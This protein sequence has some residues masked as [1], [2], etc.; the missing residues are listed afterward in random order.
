[1]EVFGYKSNGGFA[2]SF[3][4]AIV[5]LFRKRSYSE[6]QLQLFFLFSKLSNLWPWSWGEVF[7]VSSSHQHPQSTHKKKKS[8]CSVKSVWKTLMKWIVQLGCL[9][10]FL[11]KNSDDL[12]KKVTTAA[13][14]DFNTQLMKDSIMV[15]RKLVVWWLVVFSFLFLVYRQHIHWFS[16]LHL[17][18]T[19]LNGF[20]CYCESRIVL[21]FL[22]LLLLHLGSDS[23][24]TVE[25]SRAVSRTCSSLRC[26]QTPLRVLTNGVDGWV[27]FVL[28][29]IWAKQRR[30]NWIN[31]VSD[32]GLWPCLISFIT[33]AAA[34][35]QIYAD[36]N[37][38][39]SLNSRGEYDWPIA[40]SFA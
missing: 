40:P 34:A 29:L 22:L 4:N 36:R 20:S 37:R 30:S 2:W 1:M 38:R 33:A 28:F 8:I 32:A 39:C 18:K 17:L 23:V 24:R 9:V 35:M 19:H 21:L 10:I 26:F 27:I 16:A 3:F 31:C 7:V 6:R 14:N 15:C 5:P 13:E 25:S 12:K 11:K